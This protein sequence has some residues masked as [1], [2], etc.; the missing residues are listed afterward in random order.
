MGMSTAIKGSDTEQLGKKFCNIPCVFM[1]KMKYQTNQG[2]TP[3]REMGNW[4]EYFIKKNTN[5]YHS[6]SVTSERHFSEEQLK[7]DVH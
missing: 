3:M 2:D 7:F 6:I 4:N 1:Q 5:E